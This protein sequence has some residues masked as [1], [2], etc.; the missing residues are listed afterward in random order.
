MMQLGLKC[1]LHTGHSKQFYAKL[2]LDQVALNEEFCAVTNHFDRSLKITQG[3]P[4][5]VVLG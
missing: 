5:R 2:T 3:R 1:V 4:S